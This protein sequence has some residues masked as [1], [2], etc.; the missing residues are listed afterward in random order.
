[1]SDKPKKDRSKNSEVI[2][3]T[4][5]FKMPESPTKK[6]MGLIPL[7]LDKG[8]KTIAVGQLY[9]LD[10]EIEGKDFNVKLFFDHY[11]K[12]LKV[13]DYSAS[14]YKA[15]VQRVI[16]LARENNFDKIFFKATAEDWQEFLRFGFNLEGIIK[17]YFDSRDAYVVSHFGSTDRLTSAM[18]FEETAIIE[19]IMK[20]APRE[21]AKQLPK[22]YKL[23][24]AKEEDIPALVKLYRRVFKTYPSPLTHPDYIQQTMRRDMIYMAVYNR[25]ELV[26]AA[27]AEI[28]RKY[29]NAELTDCATKSK[30]RGKGLM[31][32]LLLALEERLRNEGLNMTYT[33]A[34]APS[35]PMNRVFYNLGYHY[36]GR[37]INNCDIFGQYEDMNIWMK[38][39]GTKS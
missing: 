12:R 4:D 30:E 32:I 19:E 8:I 9:G 22:D 27:S 34:R 21:E 39:L 24:E 5:E 33:L 3:E 35:K 11:N 2:E 17:Y 29:K 14:D 38:H 28:N 18:T 13:I 36:S 16:F 7:T 10:F 37:L 23:I 20:S 1:M 6:A 31:A 15:L 26:S 25:N